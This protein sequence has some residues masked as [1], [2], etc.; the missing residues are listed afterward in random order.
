MRDAPDILI[1]DEVLSVDDMFFRQK[2]EKRIREMIHSG[3]TV[4][5]VSH[6]MDTIM[7][8]CERVVWIEKGKLMMVGDA[9]E[10]CG[11]YKRMNEG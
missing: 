11:A 3:A 10:V 5:I 2:I 1:L 9:K 6:S 7:K 4:L 8:N